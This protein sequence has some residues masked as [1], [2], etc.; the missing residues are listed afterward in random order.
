MKW[1]KDKFTDN[2]ICP[3]CGYMVDHNGYGG[4]D[5]KFCPE[6]GRAVE[7]VKAEEAEDNEQTD[8]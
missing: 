6:C 5:Y 1:L 8:T 2:F 3:K 4:C 7:P